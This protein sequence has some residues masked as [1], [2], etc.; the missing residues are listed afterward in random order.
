LADIWTTD[1]DALL[2]TI[3]VLFTAAFPLVDSGDIKDEL[4]PVQNIVSQSLSC[5][6]KSTEI[7]IDLAMSP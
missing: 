2:P 5:Y 6:H 3:E 7:M 1:Q 4:N